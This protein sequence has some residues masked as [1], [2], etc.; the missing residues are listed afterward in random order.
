MN[1]KECED[2]WNKINEQFQKE[3]GSIDLHTGCVFKAVGWLA[4]EE[5]FEKG[6]VPSGFIEKLRILYDADYG[7]MTLGYHD[8]EFCE[9]DKPAQSSTE[10]TLHDKEN[11]ILYHIPEMIFHYIEEHKFKPSKEFIEFVMKQ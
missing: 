7:I 3:Y 8:C 11:K 2:K 6:E 1:N 5:L 9:S 10:K 4:F